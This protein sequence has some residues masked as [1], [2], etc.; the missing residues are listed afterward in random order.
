MNITEILFGLRMRALRQKWAKLLGHKLSC[1]DEKT[2][3]RSQAVHSYTVH[4]ARDLFER[5]GFAD[6]SAQAV[7][8]YRAATEA[9]VLFAVIARI[10]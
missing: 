6:V 1:A 8:S 3:R 2:H 4:Q 7:P 5:A 10:G 9:D